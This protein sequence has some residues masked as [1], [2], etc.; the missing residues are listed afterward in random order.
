MF[1]AVLACTVL[2]VLL[3]EAH[4]WVV[5]LGV[6]GGLAFITFTDFDLAR[7]VFLVGVLSVYIYRCFPEL[8]TGPG[9][10]GVLVHLIQ[11]VRR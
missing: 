11:A 3:V 8:K 9:Y 2:S 7:L 5:V 1:F 10:K 6:A 4:A